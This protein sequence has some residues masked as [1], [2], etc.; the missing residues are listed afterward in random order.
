MK[1]IF[2]LSVLLGYSVFG[3]TYRFTYENV[4]RKTSASKPAKYTMLLDI[5]NDAVKYYDQIHLSQNAAAYKLNSK[6]LQ[7]IIHQKNSTKN[8]LYTSD[9]TNGYYIIES[10][11]PIEWKLENETKTIDKIKVSK[12]VTSFG[13]R[14][15]VAWYNE[16]VPLS[17]G[18]YKFR[19]LPGIIVEMQDSEGLIV[20]KMVKSEKLKETE[21]TTDFLETFYGKKPKLITLEKFQDNFREFYKD[22]LRVQK[23]TLQAGNT[24]T[25]EDNAG[26]QTSVGLQKLEQQKLQIQKEIRENFVQIELDKAID[27]TK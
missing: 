18:P 25:E 21:D 27:F 9:P 8:I 19:G 15:W 16:D 10:S 23:E 13:G 2:L 24:L 4:I 7:Q 1:N 11:D 26:V 12:A 20:Y 5:N 14:K 22:P 17:E 6:S 3:Q